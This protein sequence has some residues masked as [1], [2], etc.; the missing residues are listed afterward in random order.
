MA[1]CTQ[2]RCADQTALHL[3]SPSEAY[4]SARSMKTQSELAHPLLG[5]ENQ[6][7]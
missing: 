2:N 6:S 1:L 3:V 4:R 5:C 7:E